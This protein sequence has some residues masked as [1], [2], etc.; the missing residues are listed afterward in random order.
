ME[1]T[2]KDI[3]EIVNALARHALHCFRLYV[4]DGK[5]GW[6]GEAHSA[7]WDSS[8][9]RTNPANRTIQNY[10]CDM[11]VVQICFTFMEDASEN[12]R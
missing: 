3:S 1:Y 12:S 6:R 5:A 8:C 11:R 2:D 9:A 4:I 10:L 7:Q